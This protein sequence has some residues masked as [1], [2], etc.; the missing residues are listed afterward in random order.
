MLLNTFYDGDED[1]TPPPVV[2]HAQRS[3]HQVGADGNTQAIKA[4]HEIHPGCAVMQGDK[5]VQRRIN[6][7]CAQPQGD[8]EYKEPD[9]ILREGNAEQ[10]R[11]RH[12]GAHGR[13]A[14]HAKA[15]DDP[16]A[17]Q[18]GNNRAGTHGCRD[19]SG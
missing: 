12:H 7:P 18:A 19:V 4:V 1:I 17:H 6:R 10:R 15:F 11:C 13:N 5:I 8:S 2:V 3:R 14:A 9:G 16:C